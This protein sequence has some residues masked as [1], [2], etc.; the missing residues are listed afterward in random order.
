LPETATVFQAEAKAISTCAEM[1]LMKGYNNK[2]INIYSDSQAVLKAVMNNKT[3]SKTIQQCKEN[4][5]NLAASNKVI[6][7]WIPGHEGHEGN[8]KADE[9]AKKGTEAID[10]LFKKQCNISISYIKNHIKQ[11]KARQANKHWKSSFEAIHSKRVTPDISKNK[12]KKLLNQTRD[13]LRIMMPFLTGHGR[14]KKHLHRMKLSTD[15]SCRFCEKE[16][17]AEHIMCNCEAFSR[18][19]L[20]C[21][22]KSECTLEDYANL[23]FEKFK[24]FCNLAWRQM[25]AVVDG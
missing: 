20:R 4:L 8:E 21:T 19:R 22:G 3:T 13:Q 23:N 2:T 24:E 17:T 7:T 14:F 25:W 9:L 18:T 1:I 16:E 11:W 10:N 5:K 15:T 6:L 12:T